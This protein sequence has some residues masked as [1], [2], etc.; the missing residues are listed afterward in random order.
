MK[1]K[2]LFFALFLIMGM[3]TTF[4]QKGTDAMLF[5]DVKCNG[6][7]VP[8]VNIIVK[9]STR[10]TMSDETGHFKMTNLPLGKVTIVAKAIG[11]KTNEQQVIMKKKEGTELYIKIEEDPLSMDQIVVTGTRTKHYVKDV[12]IRTEVITSKSIELK[13]AGNLYEA[14]EGT[15]GIRVE[16]QCQ[17]CN[18]SMVRMQGLG[19]ENT[20]VMI[21]GQPI[22]SGLAAVYGLQQMGMEDVDRIEVIKGAGSAL[23]GSGAIAGAINIITK[24]PSYVPEIKIQTEFGSYGT[25]KYNAFASMRNEKGNIG[26]TIT[27]QKLTGDAIDQTGEGTSRDEVN[28]KDGV[29]DRVNS[30]LNNAG[31]GLYVNGLFSE[32]DNLTLRGRYTY[33]KR[34]GGTLT[35][36]Y[37]KNPF[38]DGTESILTDRYETELCY[39]T[40]FNDGSELNFTAAYTSHNRTA[41]NDTYLCDYMDTHNDSTPD[42][43]EM[44]PYLADENTVT[45]TLTYGKNLFKNHYVLTGIQGSYDK[46]KEAGLYVVV[47]PLSIYYGTAYKSNSQKSAHEL[48]FFIQ[49]EW[50]LSNKI[51]IVPGIRIDYHHSE[52]KYNSDKKV[53]DSTFPKSKFDKTSINPRIAFKYEASKRFILRTN[54][55]TGFR[56]PYGFSEDLHLCSGS[57]RV[58]KSSDLE[59]EK[60]I[61]YNLSGDY[62]GK[63]IRASLNL[64]RTDLKNKIAFADADNNVAALGY[65]YQWENI[66]DAFVQGIEASMMAELPSDFDISC[67]FT[68][69][70]GKY[71]N[72]RKDWK[73]TEYEE[74]SKY[75]SR[76]P[77]ITGDIRL[78]YSPKDWAFS[79]D[80]NYQG[81]MYIDYYSETAGMSKIKHTSPFM[82]VNAKISKKFG[83]FKIYAAG[84]NLFG[85]LQPEKHLDDA[86][87]MY[88][89]MFGA[90]F[91]AGISIDLRR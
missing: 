73:G 46:L 61:S 87:F 3:Q 9:N 85:Y 17:Y 31:F 74:D 52:E 55:G 39:K 21:N 90:M 27:A 69:N 65:D 37:Y 12:P 16:Q 72:P 10:G 5:G 15:P 63:K 40:M 7:H 4:A 66:D 25:N 83:D 29:S 44:R 33:E 45:G 35:N 70:Q 54:V 18:F 38:T 89:P 41:T 36:D 43:R 19:S 30:D 14:L 24:E 82:L 32:N 1:M 58:W 67:N 77:A 81:K 23:Y 68:I 28:H 42:V 20:Q 60:S 75:L 26:L 80:C 8:Y 86:A 34:E 84:K 88:G 6:K 64:F 76:F 78:D 71:D 50:T 57:P 48:G 49:D 59:P 47:D 11:Y 13:N 56:A 22:Y 91:Y 51:S 62:Y 53:F 2:N 79:I